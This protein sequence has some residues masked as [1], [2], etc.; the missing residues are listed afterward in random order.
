MVIIVLINLTVKWTQKLLGPLEHWTV[1]VNCVVFS[2]SFPCWKI[3]GISQTDQKTAATKIKLLKVTSFFSFLDQRWFPWSSWCTSQS[4][5]GKLFACD[6][7]CL[8]WILSGFLSSF[9]VLPDQLLWRSGR[10]RECLFLSVLV[11]ESAFTEER[12]CC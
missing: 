9:F 2:L 1:H 10:R 11:W 12:R 4:F 3:F 8:F 5:A 6:Q 7:T